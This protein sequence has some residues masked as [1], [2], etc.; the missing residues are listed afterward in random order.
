MP[1]RPRFCCARA[2]PGGTDLHNGLRGHCTPVLLCNGGPR[3]HGSAQRFARPL[4][5]SSVVQRRSQEARICTTDAKVSVSRHDLL[6]CP[7]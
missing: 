6:W 3:R 2:V 5:T 7:Q 1:S 4:H